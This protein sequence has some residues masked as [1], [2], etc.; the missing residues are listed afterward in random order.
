MINENK[1]AMSRTWA[2][3]NLNALENDY[4]VLK[5]LLL[6]GTKFAGVC[7]ANAYGHGMIEIA[8]KLQELGADY[9]CVA[10]VDEG[11]TLRENNIT[12]PVLCLGQTDP[13]LANL[14]SRYE[15]TQAVGDFENAELLSCYAQ[16]N[17]VRIKIH[18]KLD[19]G[20]SRLGF[21]WPDDERNKIITAETIA[22]ICKLDGI[23]AEGLF[24]HF[25]K[26]DN[27]IAY[28]KMQ[29]E[30]INEA[31]KYLSRLGINFNIIHA[32]ASSGILSSPDF[33]MNM[34]RFG[35]ALYGYT[36]PDTGNEIKNIGLKPVMTVKSRIS[37]VRNLP[38]GSKISYGGTYELKRD[39][40]IAIIP[41]GYADCIPR[42]L[43]NNFSVKINNIKCPLIGRVCMDMTIIDVTDLACEI[44]SGD[45]AVIYDEELMMQAVKNSD[46]IIDEIVCRVLPRVTK[47]YIEN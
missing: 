34:C 20:M 29:Y 25:S 40:K 16:K 39:S 45:I 18:I 36:Y 7:K 37:A 17:N 44:K 6:P 24:T 13:E 9:I 12:I 3:I 2:E 19:T 10:S 11:V 26:A 33:Q 5:N 14:I 35:I 47:I 27:D 46:T 4:N 1:K 22:K 32:S 8:D 23:E 28:T 43:S 30:K 38:A 41:A 31:K 15:I 21:Y 42:N